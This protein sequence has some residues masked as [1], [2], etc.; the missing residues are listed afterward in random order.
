MRTACNFKK[1][2][3]DDE[4]IL[5]TINNLKY[6]E[7]TWEHHASC[8]KKGSECRFHFRQPKSVLKSDVG[9]DNI[10][11]TQVSTKSVLKLNVGDDN[12]VWT[13]V[14]NEKPQTK[15]FNVFTR[16]CLGDEYMNVHSK[17]CSEVLAFNNNVS[18][19]YAQHIF[20]STNYS[21]KNTQEEDR[22]ENMMMCDAWGR[23]FNK[24][25]PNE[26]IDEDDDI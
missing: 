22:F 26:K 4:Q 16:Q 3:N 8:F 9:K 25:A 15:Y 1:L 24:I 5:K 12:N 19:G 18:I 13:E 10:E 2:T 20:Y 14:S 23:I 11:W 21:T 17:L 6:Q 7:H